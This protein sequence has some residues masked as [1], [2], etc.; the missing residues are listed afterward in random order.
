MSSGTPAR[1]AAAPIPPAFCR[2]DWLVYF[3]AIS[4]VG[5]G[6]ARIPAGRSVRRHGEL[7]GVVDHGA[8]GSQTGSVDLDGR[9]VERVEHVGAIALGVRSRVRRPRLEP[10]VTASD[11]RL[12]GV[13]PEDVEA[14]PG[15]AAGERL[16]NRSYPIAS[17]AGDPD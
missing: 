9:L 10:D 1:N 15:G 14:H 4:R 6:R 16:T 8:A 12:V 17:L 13:E 2:I 3:R 11:H 7:L 5:T